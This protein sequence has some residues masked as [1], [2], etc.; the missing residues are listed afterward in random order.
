MSYSMWCKWLEVELGVMQQIQG[1]PIERLVR[2]DTFPCV[3]KVIAKYLHKEVKNETITTE[4]VESIVD[5][6]RNK[7]FFGVAL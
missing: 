3:D 5:D 2:V 1:E 7:I 4:K 6:R